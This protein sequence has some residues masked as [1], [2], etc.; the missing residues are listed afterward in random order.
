MLYA[1]P[2]RLMG[3]NV[4]CTSL[5]GEELGRVQTWG[6]EPRSFARHRIRERLDQLGDRSQV[7]QY[8][9]S[10][11]REQEAAGRPAFERAAR[12]VLAPE[13]LELVE[14]RARELVE[15]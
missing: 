3:H 9:L 6:N 14:R 10:V 4:F 2:Q 12:E 15:Q 1:T 8:E 11:L 13:L 5:A 7:I